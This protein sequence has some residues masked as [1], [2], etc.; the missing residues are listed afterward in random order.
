M[1]K[2]TVAVVQG[3][4]HQ[5]EQSGSSIRRTELP[6]Y[7]QG[8]INGTTHQ[9]RQDPAGHVQNSESVAALPQ[10]NMQWQHQQQRPSFGQQTNT[11]HD[12]H[13]FASSM[14]LISP[15]TSTSLSHGNATI[16][17]LPNDLFKSSSHHTSHTAA[18][19]DLLTMS[20]RALD[21]P[22]PNPSTPLTKKRSSTDADAIGRN[23]GHFN[24]TN[25]NRSHST[26]RQQFMYNSNA[27]QPSANVPQ[28]RSSSEQ[29]GGGLP[30]PQATSDFS[31]NGYTNYVSSS[32]IG[33]AGDN[34]DSRHEHRTIRQCRRENSFEM[35]EDG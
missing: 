15:T 26:G 5:H 13:S 12:Y 19:G 28:H 3:G 20:R 35:M 2:P 16:R 4:Q 11:R 8:M 7:R 29:A 6:I 23:T 25:M 22:P 24:F 34:E 21:P 14:D 33:T 1:L 27:Q 30:N 32:T 18:A 10:N 31:H 9:P 17:P